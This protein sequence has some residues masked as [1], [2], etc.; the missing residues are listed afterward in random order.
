MADTIS[1]PKKVQ[2]NAREGLDLHAQYKRG[3]TEPGL[4]IAR[5]L[6]EG[7]PMSLDEVKHVANYFPRHAHDNLNQDGEHGEKPSNGFIA[8]QLWGGD[9]GRE[10]ATKHKE[11][12]EKEG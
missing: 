3:G 5:K 1:I 10:W 12:A 11:D 8:W 7:Q 4:E 9:E 2:Q 6:A